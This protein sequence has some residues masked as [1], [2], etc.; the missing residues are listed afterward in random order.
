MKKEIIFLIGSLQVGGAERH[1][2]YVLPR[3]QK[4]GWVVSVITLVEKGPLAKNLECVGISV[5][6]IISE[7][8]LGITRRFP[9]FLGIFLRVI[10]SVFNL[11][12][13]FKRNSK[14]IFHFFLPETYVLGMFAASLSGFSGPKVMSRRSLNIYQHQKPLLKWLEMKMHKR[15]TKILGNSEAILTQLKE[16]ENVPAEKL[17]LIYNGINVLPLEQFKSKVETRQSLQIQPEAIVL[18]VVA[19]L[20]PYK[21]YSDLLNAL[22]RIKD[23]VLV[24]WRLLCVGRDDG[25]GLELKKQSRSLGLEKQILW[26]GSRNDVSDLFLSADIGVLC[27]HQEGFSNAILE[28]MAA[29]L[30]MVVTD[31]G[32]NKEAVI[33][34]ETGYVVPAKSPN[35]LAEALLDLIR[36]QLKRE[37]FGKAGKLRVKEFFSLEACVDAYEQFYGS[38]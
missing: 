38:L 28:G 10:P 29:G 33:Q 15:I 34:G 12:L 11:M 35:Q 17:Q 22:A 14:S 20:I 2:V 8:Y 32:G 31:V 37:T 3:L 36:D 6:S 30:P 4:K 25:I 16:E 26:L 5:T 18:I 1:L 9:R 19:N 13:L 23:K 24:D 21:G 27:S 7:R